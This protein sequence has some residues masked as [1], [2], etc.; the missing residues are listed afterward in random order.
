MK[1]ISHII[2]KLSKY[3]FVFAWIFIYNI[4]VF[5]ADS[6]DSSKSSPILSNFWSEIIK[7][8]FLAVFVIVLAFVLA[9]FFSSKVTKYM[10]NKY[11]W[12]E[13]W[14]LE[15][16]WVASKVINWT[17]LFTWFLIA[18][19]VLW[20]DISIFLWWLWFGIWFTLKIFLTNFIAW[21][22]MVTQWT[23]HNWDLIEIWNVT[24]NI[25]RIYSL[26]TSVKKYD[27]IIVYVPNVKF[28]QENVS[29]YHT[30]ERRRINVEIW[31]DYDSDV[32]KAK[33]IMRQVIDQFPNILK[34]PEPII[35]VD[36][37]DNWSI[38]LVLRFWIHS[39][40]WK[41]LRTKSNVTETI[42]LAFKQSWIII[43]FPQITLSNRVDF[44]KNNK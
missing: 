15:M 8:V 4:T 12:W 21:I 33:K 36:K 5:A 30:N 34:D 10:D 31:I 25:Q 13:T 11:S 32:V 29:N 7:N 41:Y 22:L 9:K 42:N 43:P 27:W 16:I 44:M 26:Y 28:L 24:W 38:N 17:I 23:Y 35:T 6:S 14:K 18:L 19:S 39:K 3:I 37:L 1:K 40:N 20:L 2:N